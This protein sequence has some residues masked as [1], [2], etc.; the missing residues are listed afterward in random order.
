MRANIIIHSVTGNLLLIAKV[1]QEKLQEKGV[2]ARIYRVEDPDLHLSAA[3]SNE[4]NEYYEDIISLPLAS[5]EKLRKGD[6]TIRGCPAIFSLPT[7]EMKAFLDQT[8]PLLD[9]RD[10]E[11][12]LFY[13]FASSMYGEE[14]GIS[15]ATGLQLWADSLGMDIL[16]YPP[17]VYK[18]DRDMP[19]RPGLGID[20]VAEDLSS[21][22]ISAL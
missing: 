4:A 21:A 17:Y 20:K 6:V 19:V 5:M 1:F 10:M 14:A 2:D 13:G 18:E 7:A 8:I 9:S 12:R 15:A 22:I 3:E 11:N 16:D